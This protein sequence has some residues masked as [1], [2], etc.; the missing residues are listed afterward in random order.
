MMTWIIKPIKHEYQSTIADITHESEE[1]FDDVTHESEEVFDDLQ[2]GGAAVSL[3]ALGNIAAQPP[4]T[5]GFHQLDG[6]EPGE[7]LSN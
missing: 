5:G 3:L 2:V 7:L 6:P 1:V 4:V